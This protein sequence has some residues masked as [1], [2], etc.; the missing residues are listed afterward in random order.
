[1]GGVWRAGLRAYAGGGGRPWPRAQREALA[2]PAATPVAGHR[3]ASLPDRDEARGPG[4]CRGRLQLLAV[5]VPPPGRRPAPSYRAG[6]RWAVGE[7]IPQGRCARP[8][9]PASVGRGGG[10]CA[11]LPSLARRSSPLR[12]LPP[13]QSGCPFPPA[14]ACQCEMRPVDQPPRL[15]LYVRPPS[16]AVCAPRDRRGG[17]L[18]TRAT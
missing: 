12:Q 4:V 16:P 5:H 14:R 11:Q 9:S 8:Q 17:P 6:K 18:R 7:A 13:G 3:A 10:G 2:E 15:V 1:M